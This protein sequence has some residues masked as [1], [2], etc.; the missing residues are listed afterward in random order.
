VDKYGE[1][2]S[3]YSFIPSVMNRL[4]ENVPIFQEFTILLTGHGK[5]RS[6]LH[7]FGITDNPMCPCD[8]EEKIS[9]YSKFQC[10]E[11]NNQ[12]NDTIRQIKNTGCDWTTTN[13]TIVNKYLN[14]FVNFVNPYILQY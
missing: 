6:Y 8:E 2:G 9:E 4:R 11:L 1:R 5:L 14:I 10:K 3:N 13:E 7:R 12:R